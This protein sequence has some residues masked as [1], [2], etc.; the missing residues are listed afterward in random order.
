MA[1]ELLDP[2]VVEHCAVLALGRCQT[3]DHS[4][5]TPTETSQ[6][7]PSHSPWQLQRPELRHGARYLHSNS[8]LG[9]FLGLHKPQPFICEMLTMPAC[10]GGYED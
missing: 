6:L 5:T 7:P 4:T 9:D 3:Q 1:P 8:T 2:A 10:N